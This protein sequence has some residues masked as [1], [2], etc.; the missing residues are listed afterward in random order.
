VI[1]D[2]PHGSTP[3]EWTVIAEVHRAATV[4]ATLPPPPGTGGPGRADGPGRPLFGRL[5]FG[6]RYRTF[7]GWVNGPAGER[8]GLAPILGP[9]PS[10]RALRRTLAIELAYRPGGL[11][12]ANLHLKH[13]SV[14][15]SSPLWSVSDVALRTLELRSRRVILSRVYDAPETMSPT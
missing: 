3:D 10:L 4:A 1:K 8:L 13:I 15:I 6:G 11:L 14:V 5:S 7:T 2:Q 12:A 9:P